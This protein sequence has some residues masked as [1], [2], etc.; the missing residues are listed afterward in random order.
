MVII[1]CRVLSTIFVLSLF[2][3]NMWL[4]HFGTCLNR[5]GIMPPLEV[6]RVFTN[7]IV[8]RGWMKCDWIMLNKR[9]LCWFARANGRTLD[10]CTTIK[11]AVWYFLL[12]IAC[13]DW[14]A[15]SAIFHRSWIFASIKVYL[16]NRNKVLLKILFTFLKKIN[17]E[18]YFI[19]RN[20][21][22]YTVII[23][24]YNLS[25]NILKRHEI[26]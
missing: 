11:I 3:N 25:F 15:R 14:P 24:V 17:E 12:P 6:T 1:I 2:G 13:N 4:Y 5:V 21:K 26:Q 22:I 19:K 18:N 20:S 23:F 10:L 8:P 7:V 16:N 9:K